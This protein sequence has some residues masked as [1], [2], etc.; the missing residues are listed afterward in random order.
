MRKMDALCNKGENFQKKK[1]G[2]PSSASDSTHE[3]KGCSPPPLGWP[4]RK[5][6][7]SKCRKSDEKENEP[8]SHLEDSKFTTVSS[9]MSGKL[10]LENLKY[11]I[12]GKF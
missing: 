6:T 10:G 11:N 4:I 1:D 12:F 3:A 2:V 7:L 8:V 9:K 5:A